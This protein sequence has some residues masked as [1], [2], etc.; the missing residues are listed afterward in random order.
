MATKLQ[1]EIMYD[2]IS[3]RRAQ[4]LLKFYKEMEE[5]HLRIMELEYEY[6]L[7]PLKEF[8]RESH[9]ARTERA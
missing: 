2:G 4:S 8:E 7:L 9:T 1:K 5:T 6:T 3:V